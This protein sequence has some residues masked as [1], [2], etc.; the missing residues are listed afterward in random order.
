MIARVLFCR[1]GGESKLSY[2]AYRHYG[3]GLAEISAHLSVHA[4]T[5]SRRLKQ[6]EQA[7]A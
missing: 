4:A 1:K 5:V 2:C 3:Y 6:A 7:T